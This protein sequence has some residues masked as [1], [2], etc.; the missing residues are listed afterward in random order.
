MKQRSIGNDM[1][2]CVHT[3]YICVCIY[4]AVHIYM[5]VLCLYIHLCVCVHGYTYTVLGLFL[6][7]QLH[8]MGFLAR[9]PGFYF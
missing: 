2:V 7:R 5:F 9:L 3:Y 6:H 1:Y 4:A 8:K